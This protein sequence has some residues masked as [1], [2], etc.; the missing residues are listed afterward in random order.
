M[1]VV[2]LTPNREK[3]WERFV[4]ASAGATFAHLLGWRNVVQRTYGHIPYYLMAMEDDRAVGLLPLFLFGSRIFGRFLVTAPYLSHGGLL[5]EDKEAACV[6]VKGAQKL[7]LEQRA[8]YVEIRGLSRVDHGLRLKDRYCI[9]LLPLNP[10]P[11]M[12][13]ARLEK[14][15]RTAVRKAIKSG[16]TVDRGPHLVH[17]LAEVLGRVMRDL[18]TPC[19]REAFYRNILE[20][21]PDRVE[22]FMVRFRDAFVGG[23]LTVTFKDTLA[24]PYGGCLKTYRDLA[25]MNL[26]TWEIIRYGCLQGLAHLDFGRSLLGSGTALFK[27]QWG[28]R[29][30]PLFYEYH[31]AAGAPMPDL[32]PTNPKF[33][34]AIA[35]WRRLPLFATKLLGPLITAN[36]S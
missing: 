32:D 5:V 34:L 36:I 30:L 13:W 6:L 22:I 8:Q 35:I 26:L 3:A 19:H 27:R 28:A 25:A 33:R 14:R 9:Y 18:G 31:L 2:L 1:D 23:G 11:A 4:A 21:F 17:E 24:W 12:V 16:L 10:D 7:A 15:A 29:P 20:Q